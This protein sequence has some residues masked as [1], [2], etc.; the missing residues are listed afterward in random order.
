MEHASF[1]RAA[2]TL[3]ELLVVIGIIALLIALLLPASARTR[4][5][6]AQLQCGSNLRQVGQALTAYTTHNRGSYPHFSNWHVYGGDG[7]GEDE[8]GPSWTELIEPYIGKP[9]S[10]IYLCPSFP[11]ETEFNYFIG[12][13]W[14][15][16]QDRWAGCTA[17]IDGACLSSSRCSAAT[18]RTTT[19]GSSILSIGT[20]AERP[21]T[22][23]DP[24]V[25]DPGPA[26]R[27]Y[28]L[29]V[30]QSPH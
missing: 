13:R 12:V 9:T 10:G 25:S 24:L 2:F 29:P 27:P 30:W 6:A 4:E 16:L 19:A 11:P 8:E 20:C 21:I 28:S 18:T 15:L 23:F 17:A 1:R 26:L 7:T 3:I 14:I 22:P 5:S